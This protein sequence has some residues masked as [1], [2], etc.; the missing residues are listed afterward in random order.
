[1]SV[2]YVVHLVIVGFVVCE[3]QVGDDSIFFCTEFA[4]NFGVA[5]EKG[6]GGHRQSI[7]VVAP[8]SIQ[9]SDP[10]VRLPLILNGS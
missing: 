8:P 4:G 2:E 3:K 1:M 9:F 6:G 5:I 7:V 10:E